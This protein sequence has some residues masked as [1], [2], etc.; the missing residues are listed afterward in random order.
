MRTVDE[1]GGIERPAQ[2]R[3]AGKRHEARVDEREHDDAGDEQR[4]QDGPHAKHLRRPEPVDLPPADRRAAAERDRVDGDDDTGGAVAVSLPADEEEQ[5]ER[6]HAR[7]AA[8]RAATSRSAR[9]VREPEELAV[10]AGP[11]HVAVTRLTLLPR[12]APAPTRNRRN[13]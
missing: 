5:R 1:S 8:G 7:A 11:G 4:G 12:R 6:R 9:R 3:D 13:Q 10:R 2:R